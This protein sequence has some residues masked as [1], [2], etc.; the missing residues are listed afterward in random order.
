[1]SSNDPARAEWVD[2]LAARLEAHAAERRGR[3]RRMRRAA[4]A[5]FL[6]AAGAAGA[7]ALWWPAHTGG[8]AAPRDGDRPPAG[9]RDE[10]PA[11][12]L[13]ARAAVPARETPQP[14]MRVR[15]STA[16]PEAPTLV[17]VRTVSDGELVALLA[18]Q[19]QHCAVA[20]LPGE[21]RLICDSAPR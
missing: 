12:P 1:M 14:P 6:L 11:P 19:G 13:Q 5:M 20:R 8:G 16:G 3:R 17:T 21:V 2:A 18:A 9:G 7:T 15:I 10:A 4:A